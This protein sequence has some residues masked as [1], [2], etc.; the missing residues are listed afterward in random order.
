MPDQHLN[1]WLVAVQGPNDRQPRLHAVV[2]ERVIYPSL[3]YEAGHAESL[4][5]NKAEGQAYG[6]ALDMHG[7][8]A[9]PGKIERSKSR[10]LGR[11]IHRRISQDRECQF[12]PCPGATSQS[13]PLRGGR[14]AR[15]RGLEHRERVCSLTAELS[16]SMLK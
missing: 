3:A 7:R 5:G 8:T 9:R 6:S 4:V 15:G 1:G 14:T 12:D 10:S 11:T 16:R 2:A 13:Y